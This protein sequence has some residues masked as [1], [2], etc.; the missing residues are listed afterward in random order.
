MNLTS[1]TFITAYFFN[2][3][4]HYSCANRGLINR[5]LL[6]DEIQI[7]TVAFL[8]TKNVTVIEASFQANQTHIWCLTAETWVDDLKDN[9]TMNINFT[10]R[11]EIHCVSDIG[12][13]ARFQFYRNEEYGIFKV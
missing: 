9:T 6:K 11:A 2:L 12:L 13:L 1:L 8:E 7:S 3:P 10:S 4:N 5:T